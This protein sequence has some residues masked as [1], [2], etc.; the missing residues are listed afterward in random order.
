MPTIDVLVRRFSVVS[1]RPFEEVVRRLTATIGRPNIGA[2]HDAV[3]SATT[4]TE[5][6][7]VF[8]ETYRFPGHFDLST[9]C[10]KTPYKERWM[11]TTPPRQR[12]NGEQ[13]GSLKLNYSV[14]GQRDSSP[15][16]PFLGSEREEVSFH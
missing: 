2:F 16:T 5:L 15:V 7:T 8:H 3:A 10:L 14:G 4:V 11:M 12:N 9:F 1:Q 6:E 13:S